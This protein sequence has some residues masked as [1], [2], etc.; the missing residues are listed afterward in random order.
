MEDLRRKNFESGPAP[1]DRNDS[2]GSHFQE[3]ISDEVN[4][5]VDTALGAI[6]DKCQKVVE[7]LFRSQLSVGK[8]NPNCGLRGCETLPP[9][10]SGR[11][12]LDIAFISTWTSTSRPA[13]PVKFLKRVFS[14]TTTF[15]HRLRSTFKKRHWTRSP[16]N[17]RC[18]ISEPRE[19]QF[20]PAGT[21]QWH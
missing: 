21:Q 20:V 5:Q 11:S 12:C 17:V 6:L 15:S 16:N 19:C 1:R 8:E 10:R 4:Q 9:I 18:R 3:G 2:I 7:L 13:K 14:L